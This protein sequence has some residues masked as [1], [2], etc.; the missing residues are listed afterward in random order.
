MDKKLVELTNYSSRIEG[1]LVAKFLEGCGLFA[2]IRSDD[3][4]GVY[5]AMASSNGVFIWVLAEQLSEA[6]L[7]LEAEPMFED[8]Q[9]S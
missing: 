9:K 1:E 2:E 4:G 8:E 7:L 3:A 5:N 6:R